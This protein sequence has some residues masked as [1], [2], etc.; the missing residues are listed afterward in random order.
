MKPRFIYTLFLFTFLLVAVSSALFIKLR[1]NQIR[2]YDRLEQQILAST[3]RLQWHLW[4]LN[5]DN[6]WEKYKSTSDFATIKEGRYLVTHNH[7]PMPLSNPENGELITISIYT[8]DGKIV[9]S[10][11]PRKAFTIEEVD[12][13]TLVLDFDTYEGEGWFD[14]LGLPSAEFKTWELLSLE[15]GMEVAQIDWDNTTGHVEWVMIKDVVTDNGIP[16]LILDNHIVLGASGGGVF[17]NGYH[18]AN[19]WFQA[20]EIDKN[21]GTVVDQFS[22][23]ALN[24]PRMTTVS[25]QQ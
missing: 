18:I 10:E 4:R 20:T 6:E 25:R 5:G 23:A 1:L 9:L 2:E 3:V 8:A 17:W 19:T 11:M 22:V 21:R 7:N 16:K 13:E 14:F 12:A 24:S 15:P